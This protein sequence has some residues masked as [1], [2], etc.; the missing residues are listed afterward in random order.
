MRG[1]PS[2]FAY[3]L[4]VVRNTREIIAFYV[5]KRVSGLPFCHYKME[6]RQS[7]CGA[8]AEEGVLVFDRR[9]FEEF[10]H[11][12]FDWPGSAD[13]DGSFEQA[14]QCQEKEFDFFIQ[15]ESHPETGL[16]FDLD[17]QHGCVANGKAEDAV[18]RNI[19]YAALDAGM[20]MGV[21]INGL[22][23]SLKADRSVVFPFEL[24]T[25]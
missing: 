8:L 7:S 18:R 21:F 19:L 9:Q 3:F 22:V 16:T 5:T 20:R 15:P 4:I 10:C 23:R 25:Q 13:A 1:P 14:G 11:D 6:S 24:F 12:F 17:F 2:L